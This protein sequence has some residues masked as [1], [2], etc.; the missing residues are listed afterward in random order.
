V[1]ID[2]HLI[3]FVKVLALLIVDWCGVVPAGTA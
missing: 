3:P 2:A 1:L